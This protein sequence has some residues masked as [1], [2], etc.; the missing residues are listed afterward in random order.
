MR[1]EA[2]QGSELQRS[3]AR[4]ESDGS[5]YLHA[6][7][8]EGKKLIRQ[9]VAASATGRRGEQKIIPSWTCWC[10][11]QKL[12]LQK[13]AENKQEQGWGLVM[14]ARADVRL[15]EVKMLVVTL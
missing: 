5:G 3:S 4:A 7:K 11:T 15:L 8:R 14:F 12:V 6:R 10:S 2:R 1:N 13:R 9:S